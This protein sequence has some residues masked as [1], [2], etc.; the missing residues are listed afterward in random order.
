MRSVHTT[1]AVGTLS[2]GIFLIMPLM[3]L[4]QREKDIKLSLIGREKHFHL[5]SFKE[6]PTQ[7][8]NLKALTNTS[9]FNPFK[10]LPPLA[11]E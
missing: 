1:E 9:S 5:I 8:Q 7:W 10:Y 4:R 6:L 2:A 11:K 3:H